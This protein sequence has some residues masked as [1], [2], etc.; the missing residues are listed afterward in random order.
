MEDDKLHEGQEPTD[1]ID[2]AVDPSVGYV[3]GLQSDTPGGVS[4]STSAEPSTPA[5]PSTSSEPTTPAA[6]STSSEPTTPAA[7]STS[8]EP[9]TPSGPGTPEPPKESYA[10]LPSTNLPAVVVASTSDVPGRPVST[11]TPGAGASAGA[12]APAKTPDKFAV[13]EVVGFAWKAMLQYFW[14]LTGVYTCNFL[15]QSVP[16]VT[17]MV[18]NYTVSTSAVVTFISAVVSLISGV[19]GFIITLGT[20]NLWLKIVDGDTVAVRDVYSKYSRTWNFALA[21][22]VYGLMVG[23][24]YICLIIPGIYLQ[25]R[26]QFYPYFILESNASPLTSLKASW[27]ITKGSMA[28]LIF[29]MIVNYFIN[30]VGFLCLLIGIYPAQLVQQIALAKTYRLLRE[31]TPL[32]E[33]PP[34][35]MPVALISDSEP[36]PQAA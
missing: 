26:F 19:V 24:G 30:W 27:A 17:S 8:S 25:L 33:M 29:L 21:S 36:P 12:G 2:P 16:V 31:H 4:P 32:S 22:I 3:F 11:S 5:A 7:P 15:V 9:S 18:L 23:A 13:D 35:L 14:P 28:E 34:G 1:P 6:P 20:Y 10:N